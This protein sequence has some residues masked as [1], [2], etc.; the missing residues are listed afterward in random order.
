MAAT[1][2]NNFGVAKLLIKLGA[3]VN[4]HDNRIETSFLLVAAADYYEV[5]NACC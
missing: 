4:A 1:Y 5:L 3:D 2:N